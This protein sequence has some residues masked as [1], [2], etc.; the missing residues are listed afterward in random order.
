MGKR[1]GDG[2]IQTVSKFPLALNGQAIP[3]FAG[4]TPFGAEDKDIC[5]PEGGSGCVASPFRARS[6]KGE[7]KQKQPGGKCL[8]IL[9]PIDHQFIFHA[10]GPLECQGVSGHWAIIDQYALS[11]D[12]P[13]YECLNSLNG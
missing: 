8:I 6:N 11:Q 2:E 12:V 10:D 3:G 9:A 1:A 13:S 7:V 5:S 4:E